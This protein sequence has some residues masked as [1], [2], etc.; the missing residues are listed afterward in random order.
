MQMRSEF[1]TA[2][3]SNGS[4]KDFYMYISHFV[5]EIDATHC[6]LNTDRSWNSQLLPSALTHAPIK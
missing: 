1:I 5:K 4:F 2:L 3:V 6:L